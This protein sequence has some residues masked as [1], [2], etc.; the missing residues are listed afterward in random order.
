VQGPAL[1]L[2]AI[3][4]FTLLDANSKLLAGGYGVGQVVF[5]RFAVLVPLFFLLRAAWP[6]LGGPLTSARPGLHAL[7]AVMMMISAAGFFLAFRHLPLAEGY[8]MFFTSPFLTMALAALVLGEKVP[9][10]AWFWCAVGFGGVLVAMAPKLG[11]SGTAA[12]LEGYL[13]LALAVCSYSVTQTVNR[14][15]RG[16]NGLA[17]LV[18]WPGLLGLVVFGPL[19]AWTWQSSPIGDLARLG[20]NGVLAGAGAV[21]AAAAYR[22]ADAAR[23]GPYSFVALPSSVAL[24]WLV[25]H[26]APAAATLAGGVIVVFACVMSERARRTHREV[27]APLDPARTSRVRVYNKN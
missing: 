18:V 3:V 13:W 5:M 20:L 27:A 7:R 10:R 12:D 1:M 15:L 22:Y 6:G 23:L 17:A 21:L 2:T 19:A 16:E 8:L 24:D 26:H 4:V 25:W 11:G 14:S 9:A